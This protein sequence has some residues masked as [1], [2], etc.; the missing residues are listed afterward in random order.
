MGGGEQN[1]AGGGAAGEVAPHSIGCKE[2]NALMQSICTPFSQ[3]SSSR[4]I[5]CRF[6]PYGGNFANGLL[7][8]NYK[9]YASPVKVVTSTMVP[10]LQKSHVQTTEFLAH[11]WNSEMPFKRVRNSAFQNLFTFC[12]GVQQAL[13]VTVALGHFCFLLA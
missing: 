11:H 7:N 9:S 8:P 3:I 1:R 10:I 4:H 6:P 12:Q 5:R 13:D 2:H